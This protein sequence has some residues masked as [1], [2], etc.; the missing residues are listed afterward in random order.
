[1]SGVKIESKMLLSYGS[2]DRTS[3][4]A[5]ARKADREKYITQSELRQ[6]NSD[7]VQ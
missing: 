7:S 4:R 6:K 1:M 2:V 3:L 5:K